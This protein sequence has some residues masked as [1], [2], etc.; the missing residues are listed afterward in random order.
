LEA[1]PLFASRHSL[2]AAIRPL[3]EGTGVY[4]KTQNARADTRV[5]TQLQYRERLGLLA[6]SLWSALNPQKLVHTEQM[7]SVRA[8]LKKFSE[9]RRSVLRFVWSGCCFCSE[10]K[11]ETE[12]FLSAPITTSIIDDG[13]EG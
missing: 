6:F 12:E 8:N 9:K 5:G 4:L 10:S 3:T 7:W 2:D 13:T 11:K 1:A